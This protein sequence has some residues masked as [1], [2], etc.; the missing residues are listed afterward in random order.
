MGYVAYTGSNSGAN[1]LSKRQNMLFI[2]YPLG[3]QLFGNLKQRNK[4]KLSKELQ[5]FFFAK[6]KTYVLQITAPRA[7]VEV[8]SYLLPTRRSALH[9]IFWLV[10]FSFLSQKT[11]ILRR[12]KPRCVALLCTYLEYAV[13]TPS[14]GTP[15]KIPK[16][17]IWGT[18]FISFHFISSQHFAHV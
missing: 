4:S 11:Q 17:R 6:E 18:Q 8:S 9:S 1:S 16:P 5:W 15:A 7:T 13:L 2:Y 14:L 12:P 3:K 10:H